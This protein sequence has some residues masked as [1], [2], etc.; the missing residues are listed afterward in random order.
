MQSLSEEI[1]ISLA[2]KSLEIQ[3]NNS[4]AGV[5]RWVRRTDRRTHEQS[6]INQVTTGEDDLDIEDD[7]DSSLAGIRVGSRNAALFIS[8]KVI[9]HHSKDSGGRA[10]E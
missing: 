10:T 9:Q 3:T 4:V 6:M 2:V 5:S 1:R 8:M 7:S